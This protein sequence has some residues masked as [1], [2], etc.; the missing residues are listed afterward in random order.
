[1]N[2]VISQPMF[3]PWVGMFEQIRLADVY[4]HYS[5]V[6]FSKGSFVN[7]V[8]IKT[9]EGIKWLTVPL[10]GLSL[11]QNINEVLIDERKDWRRQHVAT[12]LRA[13]RDSRHCAEM[14][15]LVESVY[16]NRYE[17]IDQLSEAS[18][19]AVCRFFGLDIGRRY[20]DVQ[21]LGVKGESSRRVLDLVLKVGGDCYITGLGASHYLDHALF[22]TCSV[23]VKYME[24]RKM[25]Y[26]QL[27]GPFTPYVSV[28]DLIANLG[29]AGV[30]CIV[31]QTIHWKVFVE[32]G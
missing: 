9:A 7:R 29:R 25:V 2:V 24:Y 22:E 11:G 14:I 21:D 10:R 18:L 8:Q 13:Y 16:S 4:I 30:A 19:L 28:L 5:D 12:L 1:M 6:Q 17:T 26:P 27:H 23:S 31:S 20:L 32:H 3:F 15:S